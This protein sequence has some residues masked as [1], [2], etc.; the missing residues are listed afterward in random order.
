MRLSDVCLKLS[1]LFGKKS[2]EPQQTAPQ[3][4]LELESLLKA[5][6]KEPLK[7]A[8][9]QNL[10]AYVFR[11]ADPDVSRRAYAGLADVLTESK[12]NPVVFLNIAHF[13]ELAVRW[14]IALGY[15]KA[16]HKASDPDPKHDHVRNHAVHIIH[17]SQPKVIGRHYG[18]FLSNPLLVVANK[19]FPEFIPL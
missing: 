19:K 15:A 1:G 4:N 17:R 12:D 9:Y 10:G 7:R 5:V 2:A 13:A 6:R 8:P 14:D 11:M 18:D 3:E 16:A